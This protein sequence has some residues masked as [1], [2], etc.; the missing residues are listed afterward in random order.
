ML[1]IILNESLILKH[2][3]EKMK[4]DGYELEYDESKKLYIQSLEDLDKLPNLQSIILDSGNDD[5]YFK[6]FDFLKYLPNL[7]ILSGGC[8][9]PTLEPLKYCSSLEVLNLSFENKII[10]NSLYLE[11]CSQLKKLDITV[12][13]Y[14]GTSSLDLS[15]LNSLKNL[16]VIN[17]NNYKVDNAEILLELPN[18]KQVHIDKIDENSQVLTE[19]RNKGVE[20]S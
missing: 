18:L 19:L 17:I 11:N 10:S 2:N 4:E 20:V 9:V 6:N 16:E 14:D 7:K 1:K 5:I 8:S 15:Q 3:V 12:Y 13:K